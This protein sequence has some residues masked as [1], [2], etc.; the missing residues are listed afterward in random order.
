MKPKYL[1]IAVTILVT[2]LAGTA[3]GPASPEEEPEDIGMANPASVYC[4]EQGGT[5]EIR[6]SKDSSQFGMCVFDDGS[7]CEEWAYFR[8]ECSPGDFPEQPE[9][10]SFPVEENAFTLPVI[11]LY[12]QVISASRKGPSEAMLVLVTQGFPEIFLSGETAEIEELIQRLKDKPE[13]GNKANF[14]GSLDCPSMDQCLLTVSKMRVDGPGEELAPEV[15]E[16]WEGMIYDGPP[17]PRSG[18]DD[19]FALLGPYPFEYGI[20]SMDE[21]INQQLESL[22]DTDQVVRIWGELYTGR[23]DWNATQIVVTRI[24][25]ASAD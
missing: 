7:E 19:Y 9:Q 6:T 4:E 13:P 25:V 5:L 21:S 3:C 8:G 1:L 2:I 10:E 24:E 22:R 18:G 20:W 11:A 17:G 16:G 15:V 12:G 23:M 14:W